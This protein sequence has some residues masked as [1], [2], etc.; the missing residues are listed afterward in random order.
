[1]KQPNGFTL[2]ELIVVIAI[3][4]VLSA[5]AIPN[6]IAY[7]SNQRLGASA[8]EILGAIKETRM[9]AVIEQ[10]TAIITFNT[11][12]NS[13][14]AFFDDGSGSGGVAGNE[15]QDG[16]EATIVA[17]ELPGDIDM[18][19]ASFGTAGAKN[20][21]DMRG[22]ASFNGSVTFANSNGLTRGVTVLQSGH[23]RIIVP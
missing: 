21:F 6:F 1:M 8:R 2:L 13:Y 22:M 19:G 18:T 5:V 14:L 10:R 15:I 7:R 17:G 9:R 12:T 23:A 4:A 11:T 3:A 16:T 20:W